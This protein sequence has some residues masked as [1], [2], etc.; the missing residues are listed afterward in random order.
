MNQSLFVPLCL[1]LLSAALT[2]PPTDPGTFSI[3]AEKGKKIN[4]AS[5]TTAVDCSCIEGFLRETAEA[6]MENHSLLIMRGGRI[7]FERYAY[8]YTAEIPHMMFSVTKSIVGTAVGFAIDE[9]LL[10]LDTKIIDL[11]P[12]YERSDDPRW[13]G[14]T[15]ESL[16]TM[17]SGKKYSF[18]RDM[19]KSDYA[20]DFMK[21]PFR[22]KGGFL[23][24]NDDAHMLAVA[25]A[26]AAG[27]P[28][29]DYLMPRLFEPLGIEKPF[30]ETD[31]RGYCVGGTGIYLK[32][33]D[34]AR[35]C[36]CYLH[37]GRQEGRQ[38][39]PKEWA[40]SAGRFKVETGE[41]HNYGYLFWCDDEGNYK[42]GG[43]FGQYGVIYPQYDAVVALTSCAVDEEGF[44]KI[45]EKHF[46]RAFERAT[47]EGAAA[48]LEHFLKERDEQAKIPRSAR[49][50][51]EKEIAGR[52]YRLNRAVKSLTGMLNNPASIIP[53]ALNVTFAQRPRGS[54]DRLSFEFGENDCTISWQ[55]G[56]SM[57]RLLCGMDGEPR[58][59]E[60]ERCGYPYLLWSYCY[61]EG[62]RLIV[63]VKPINTV[64]TQRFEFTFKKNRLTLRIR[65]FPDFAE[66]ARV[67]AV[68]SGQIPDIKVITP[69]LLRIMQG[70]L[71]YTKLPLP[72]KAVSGS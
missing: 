60:I 27:E 32:T 9:E 4:R 50:P 12:S 10:T 70:A 23:Y 31:A 71:Q 22:K 49:S 46:P 11:F 52:C 67:N 40:Q 59:A 1:I 6:G 3:D 44:R 2:G 14:L 38:V 68:P 41:D 61:W 15:V 63:V 47:G 64:A 55:E 18:L 58:L 24:S 54:A 56:E 20:E 39:I 25:V 43:M 16:L 45:Y 35:L 65:S 34:I 51:L 21:A 57:I 19:S 72:Y 69:V 29:V 53:M 33:G 42:M 7:I 17:H 36:N 13:D 66:F 37:G 48:S 30:W 28:L 26:N 8:P 62:P 5:E